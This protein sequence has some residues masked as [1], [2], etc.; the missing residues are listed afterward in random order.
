M[1]KQRTPEDNDKTPE[2]VTFRGTKERVQV[3]SPI[4]SPLTSKN[5]YQDTHRVTSLKK[6]LRSI[7]ISQWRQLVE[8][9]M[10]SA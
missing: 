10:L 8:A 4:V 6:V 3:L 9:E 7:I 2:Q 5:E 1:I